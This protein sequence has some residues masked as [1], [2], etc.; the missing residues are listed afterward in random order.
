M[1][2]PQTLTEIVS[3]IADSGLDET[4]ISSLRSQYKG[5]H[6]TYCNDDD[7]PNNEPVVEHD[8]FNLYLVDGHDHCMCLT[9]SFENAT[10]IVVAEIYQD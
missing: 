2:E 9:N 7:I 3:S 5:I 8:G 6:F 4:I 10:G 1:I